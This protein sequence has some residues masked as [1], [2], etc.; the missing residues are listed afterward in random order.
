MKTPVT[1]P[2][3]F[4]L[5]LGPL[6]AGSALSTAAPVAEDGKTEP[7]TR[8][9][10]TMI[11]IFLRAEKGFFRRNEIEAGRAVR[12]APSQ[13]CQGTTLTVSGC[14]SVHV[15]LSLSASGSAATFE[16]SV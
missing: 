13:R 11:E 1:R 7:V 8:D 16:H 14:P 3:V 15:T 9:C 2:A 5:E 10:L 6:F 12:R 4:H